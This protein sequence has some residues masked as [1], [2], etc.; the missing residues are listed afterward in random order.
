LWLPSNADDWIPPF[1]KPLKDASRF[2]FTILADSE[3]VGEIGLW[4]L[5]NPADK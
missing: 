3:I 1:R 4:G 5:I 2:E